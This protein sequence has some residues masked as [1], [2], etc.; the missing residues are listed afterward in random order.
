MK[1]KYI[2]SAFY[3]TLFFSVVSRMF[4]LFYSVDSETGLFLSDRSKLYFIIEIIAI[5]CV[6]CLAFLIKRCP[7]RTPRPKIDISASAFL[8]TLTLAFSAY[9][10]HR[11]DVAYTFPFSK[12]IY[13]AIFTLCAVFMFL[14]GLRYFTSYHLKRITYIAPAVF[15]LIYSLFS[16]VEISKMPIISENI[17]MI[18]ASLATIIFMLNF[19]KL[20]NNIDDN[21]NIHKKLLF[22]GMLSAIFSETFAIPN[23]LLYVSGKIG[24]LH[25]GIDTFALFFS[26]GIFVIVFLAHFFSNKNLRRHSKHSES[27]KIISENQG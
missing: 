2:F 19:A 9:S 17:L 26:N 16:Y 25:N 5:V 14:Y 24:T 11:S 15:W 8:Y 22:F 23:L 4:S 7:F 18:F 10:N 1:C 27:N 13:I 12:L 6:S 21:K 20:A 3:I